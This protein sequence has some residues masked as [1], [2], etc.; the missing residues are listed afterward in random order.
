MNRYMKFTSKM[1]KTIWAMIP[2]YTD[3]RIVSCL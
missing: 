3:A 2:I 1:L